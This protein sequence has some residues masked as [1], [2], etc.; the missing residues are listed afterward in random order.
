M[1]EQGNQS[2]FR[3]LIAAVLSMVVLFAWTYFY[4][5]TKPVSNSNSETAAVNANTAQSPLAVPAAPVQTTA[6][7]VEC[8]ESVAKAQPQLCAGAKIIP[9]SAAARTITLSSQLYEVKLDSRGGG[10]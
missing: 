2:Q 4:A 9:D 8:E 6:A 3:F 7:Q 10:L 5:P 1:Q